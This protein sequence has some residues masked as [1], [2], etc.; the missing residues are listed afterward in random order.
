MTISPWDFVK[1]I[2]RQEHH[3]GGRQPPS[4]TKYRVLRR[5]LGTIWY[6]MWW[7]YYQASSDSSH[8]RIRK[9]L[10][11]GL[12]CERLLVT[13]G[14][15]LIAILL[16]IDANEIRLSTLMYRINVN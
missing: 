12:I 3:V 14:L 10:C 5:I 6:K 15:K 4:I 7:G 16:T 1:I 2:S 13:Y 8:K 11:R 9:L